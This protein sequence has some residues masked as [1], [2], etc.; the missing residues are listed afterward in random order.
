VRS[1]FVCPFKVGR[2]LINAKISSPFREC[3]FREERSAAE[4]NRR[5]KV[6][7]ARRPAGFGPW[8]ATPDGSQG[9]PGF[10]L[11]PEKKKPIPSGL[12]NAGTASA[13]LVD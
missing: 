10:R 5:E 7:T 9:S 3:S 11:D 6:M 1:I 8:S 2:R 13:E 4:P 12:R